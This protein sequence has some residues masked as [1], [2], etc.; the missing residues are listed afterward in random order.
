MSVPNHLL[1][2]KDHEWVE[3][4]EEYALVGIT[5]YAQSQLGDVI[6]VEF[7]EIGEDLISGSSFGEVE[8][9]K[10]V[11]DLFAPISGKVLSINEEIED[12]PDLVNS[13]PYKK[14]WLVKISPSNYEEKD[15]LMNFEEYK[16]FIN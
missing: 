15:G 6:F 9:V 7:P 16:S 3:F 14:G 2:T 5:D 1:Y 4:K 11:S 10:T 8:A 13:D 12:T